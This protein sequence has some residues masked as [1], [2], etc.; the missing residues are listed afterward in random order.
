MVEYIV[1]A[2]ATPAVTLN[3]F[4][5][6]RRV[7]HNSEDETLGA[8]LAAAVAWAE[9]Y[10][11]RAFITQTWEVACDDFPR[12]MVYPQVELPRGSLQSVT[13]IKY[14]D[15]SNVEQTLDPAVY[16]V[17]TQRDPGRVL[18]AYDQDWPDVLDYPNSVRIQFV[19]GYG[20]TPSTVPKAVRQA[21]LL[22]ASHFDVNREVYIVGTSVTEIPISAKALLQPYRL[23][24]R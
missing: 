23:L 19:C 24:H 6:H 22:M 17:H 8:Y 18:L 10:T 21:I 4:K 13:S 15:L 5:E 14:E 3:D 7:E 11:R 12:D 20:D 2:P 16:N 1:T 9:M